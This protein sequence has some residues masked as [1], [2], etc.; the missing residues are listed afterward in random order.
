MTKRKELI[1]ATNFTDM[2]RFIDNLAVII[3]NG[4]FEKI[5]HEL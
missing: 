3:D 2:F 5:Y 4:E 1:Q